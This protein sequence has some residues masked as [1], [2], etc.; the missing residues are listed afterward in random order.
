MADGNAARRLI[1]SPANAQKRNA[2]MV[3]A[4]GDKQAADLSN[5]LPD[6]LRGTSSSFNTKLSNPNGRRF[7]R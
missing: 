6:S 1:L 3:A 7:S 2:P 5:D 4:D